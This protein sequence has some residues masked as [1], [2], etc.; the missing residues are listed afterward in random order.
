MHVH[1]VLLGCAAYE[2]VKPHFGWVGLSFKERI[3]EVDRRPAVSGA[4]RLVTDKTP[5]N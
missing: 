2:V 5:G 4:V 1:V 3:L